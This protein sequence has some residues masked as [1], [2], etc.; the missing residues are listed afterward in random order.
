[1]PMASGSGV[2]PL[3]DIKHRRER[4]HTMLNE[5]SHLPLDVWLEPEMMA[6]WAGHCI[7]YPPLV[8]V[9]FGRGDIPELISMVRTTHGIDCEEQDDHV[10][11]KQVEDHVRANHIAACVTNIKNKVDLERMFRFLRAFWTRE[12]IEYEGSVL[13][14]PQDSPERRGKNALD[15]LSNASAWIACLSIDESRSKTYDKGYLPEHQTSESDIGRLLRRRRGI[16]HVSDNL[17]C[18]IRE[19]FDY[20]EKTQKQAEEFVRTKLGYTGKDWQSKLQDFRDKLTGRKKQILYCDICNATI[21]L[22]TWPGQVQGPGAA[23]QMKFRE[24]WSCATCAEIL[25]ERGFD[26]DCFPTLFCSSNCKKAGQKLHAYVAEY[27]FARLPAKEKKKRLFCEAHIEERIQRFQAEEKHE[28]KKADTYALLVAAAG[29][30]EALQEIVQSDDKTRMKELIE[31]IKS[32]VAEHLPRPW[33]E[34]GYPKEIATT[35]L[36]SDQDAQCEGSS[37]TDASI[38]AGKRAH[39]EGTPEADALV[40]AE[41]TA[42]RDGKPETDDQR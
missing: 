27:E 38:E 8:R 1:M 21:N 4:V 22:K 18:A 11:V 17:E 35:S 36:G 5:A 7:K 16:H 41:E 34:G 31:K 26:T 14:L 13:C 39:G 28:K 24:G 40:E 10:F 3:V 19:A 12:K 23:A 2:A 37:E 20:M 33:E 29:G 6:I 42:Q 15:Y 30:P 9:F 32:A 25:Q